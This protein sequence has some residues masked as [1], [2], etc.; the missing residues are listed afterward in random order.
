MKDIPLDGKIHTESIGIETSN[1][2]VS[3]NETYVKRMQQ[4]GEWGDGVMIA[5]ATRLY[6]RTIVVILADKSVTTPVPFTG[7]VH[8]A[9]RPLSVP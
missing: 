7:A 9:L 3:A 5:S 1:S 8:S 4:P 6:N 2:L